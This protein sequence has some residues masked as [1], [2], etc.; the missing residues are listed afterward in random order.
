M[1]KDRI[2]AITV[3]R[4]EHGWFVA[5]SDDLPGLYIAAENRDAVFGDIDSAIVALFAAKGEQVTVT[6]VEPPK[7]AAADGA[8]WGILRPLTLS[9]VPA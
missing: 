2:I 7:A 6:P 5:E 4:N 3:R 9:G 8:F 1:S